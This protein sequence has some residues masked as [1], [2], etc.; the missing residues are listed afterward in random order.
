M[1]MTKNIIYQCQIE[2]PLEPEHAKK[3]RNLTKLIS[4]DL[5]K[6]YAFKNNA[7]YFISE[8]KYMLKDIPIEPFFKDCAWYYEILRLIYDSYFDQYDNILYV[9][10][11]IIPLKTADNIFNINYSGVAGVLERSLLIGDNTNTVNHWD[12]DKID[13]YIINEKWDNLNIALPK[14]E[15][16]IINGGL[17]LFSKE[18]R[19]KARDT[20]DNWQDWGNDYSKEKDWMYSDQHYLSAQYAKHNINITHLD[21]SWNIMASTFKPEK[22]PSKNFLHY[23]AGSKQQLL[24]YYKNKL[25]DIEY[26]DNEIL[27]QISN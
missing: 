6:G 21:S 10:T 7:D 1:K 13:N 11:D 18:A 4:K 3:V 25:L 2:N 9:D 23:F 16:N 8:E 17:V 12:Y 22:Y 5:F 14:K 19:L 24:K 26:Y 20:F 27:S 15:F